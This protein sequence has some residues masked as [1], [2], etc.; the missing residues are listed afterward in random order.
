MALMDFC[1]AHGPC[2]L[3]FLQSFSCVL[4]PIKSPNVGKLSV[5]LSVIC[6]LNVV[7]LTVICS[8][9]Y[10]INY[11]FSPR[12]KTWVLSTY[13]V[14]EGRGLM[15]ALIRL[16]WRVKLSTSPAEPSF[17]K[18][19]LQIHLGWNRTHP[20]RSLKRR[21]V[22]QTEGGEKGDGSL[23]RSRSLVWTPPSSIKA[24]WCAEMSAGLHIVNYQG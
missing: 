20:W 22:S 12:F 18:L 7:S 13:P 19:R 5:N 4:K 8:D 24:T 23:D 2:L 16:K 10:L 21:A 11:D 9:Q 15:E 17:A 6:S 14:P 1:F 3:I